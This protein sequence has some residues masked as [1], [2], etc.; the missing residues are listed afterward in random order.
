[1]DKL[2]LSGAETVILDGGLGTELE[3]KGADVTTRLWSARIL[4]EDPDMIFRTHKEFFEAG[5]DVATT[6]SYQATVKGFEEIGLDKKAAEDL[7]RSSIRI[8]KKARDE[9]WSELPK[10]DK[11]ARRFP[12][13]AASIGCYGASLAD[14]SEFNGRYKD[15]VTAEQ[16][17]DFHRGRLVMLLEEGP[18]LVAFETVPCAV[19]VM[20]L[21]ELL[22]EPEI[23]AFG[24][25]A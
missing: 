6:A 19:E 18:D 16:L 17:K 21:A 3:R 2:H 23:Q 8:A 25:P 5:A 9:F 13:V 10:A 12:L 24:T 22:E 15:E 1:M 4:K 11:S 7:I 20:A 14:G